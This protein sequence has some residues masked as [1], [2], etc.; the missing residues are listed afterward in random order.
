MNEFTP[1][2]AIERLKELLTEANIPFDT[3][4][5]PNLLIE[6]VVYPSIDN[7][8]CSII[9]GMGTI[10]YRANLLEMMDHNDEDSDDV[11]GYLT[12]ETVLER[13]SKYHNNK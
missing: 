12:P 10:G 1:K 5:D 8:D 9:F 2:T 11:I 6:R 7:W 3:N 13:L 4:D